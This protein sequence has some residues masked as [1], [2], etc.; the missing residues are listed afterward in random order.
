MIAHTVPMTL[1]SIRC[2]SNPGRKRVTVS[3]AMAVVAPA[4]R[5]RDW[6]RMLY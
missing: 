2:S 3:A 5:A 6:I 1:P 4:R